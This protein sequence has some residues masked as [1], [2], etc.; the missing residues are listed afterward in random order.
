MQIIVADNC[1]NHFGI[2]QNISLIMLT[3]AI[4]ADNCRQP[5]RT[6]LDHHLPN[7]YVSLYYVSSKLLIF[8]N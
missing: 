8:L 6:D 4:V 1:R 3:Q 2:M 5:L 7:S